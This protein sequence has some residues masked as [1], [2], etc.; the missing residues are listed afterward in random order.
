M[1][2][3]FAMNFSN[4]A[5]EQIIHFSRDVSIPYDFYPNLPY[6]FRVLMLRQKMNMNTFILIV[7]N[8]RSSKSYC[9]LKIAEEYSKLRNMTFDVDKQLTFDDIK[10]FLIWSV[11]ATDS[12]FILDETGTT[13]SP[14]L[15]WSLQQRVMRKFCQVG[16]FRKNVLIWALP[17]IVFIQ[18]GF[19]F[20]TNYALMTKK[21]GTVEVFKIVVNQLVGKGFPDRIETMNFQLPSQEIIDKYENSKKDWNKDDLEKDIDWLNEMNKPYEKKLTKDEIKTSYQKNIIGEDKAIESL[22]KIGYSTENTKILIQN[23]KTEN[24]VEQQ[25]TKLKDNPN[26]I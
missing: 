8:P 5:T 18:K 15:F 1:P 3:Q 6:I 10:K 23:F 16:G 26:W 12:I 13:L 7:G 22:N 19:R 2:K 9:A 21:Q 20:L 24:I 14:D 4:F 25:L 11:N 17:S